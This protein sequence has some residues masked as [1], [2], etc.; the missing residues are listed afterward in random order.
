MM[1]SNLDQEEGGKGKAECEGK[2][3]K[4][5]HDKGEPVHWRAIMATKLKSSRA[6]MANK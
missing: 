4:T 1:A 2:A 6:I 5:E 3:S